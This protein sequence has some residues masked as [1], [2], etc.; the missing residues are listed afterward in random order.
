[1]ERFKGFKGPFSTSEQMGEWPIFA[2]GEDKITCV[3][4]CGSE[5]SAN[6]IIETMNVLHCLQHLVEVYDSEDGKQWT[7]SS[8]KEAIANARAAIYKALGE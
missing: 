6:K 4:V 5:E 2:D 3:R 8:K 7:T 1:M